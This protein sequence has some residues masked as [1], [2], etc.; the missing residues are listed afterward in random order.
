MNIGDLSDDEASR[1]LVE[2]SNLTGNITE[3]IKNKT[4]AY[5]IVL[6]EYLEG[7]KYA[8]RAEI[9]SEITPEYLEMIEAKNLEKW[10]DKVMSGIKY[11]LRI[12]E[13]EFKNIL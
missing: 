3:M 2:L 6:L 10:L 7:E 11:Y 9:R 8:N 1:L 5:N 4:L 13:K 12:K